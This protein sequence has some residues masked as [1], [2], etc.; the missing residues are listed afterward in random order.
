MSMLPQNEMYAIMSSLLNDDHNS[1]KKYLNYGANAGNERLL[2]ALRS[3][4]LQ[5]TADDDLG[6]FSSCNEASDFF[7]TT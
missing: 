6:G 4:L 7:I 3:F 1:W 2:T 5:R